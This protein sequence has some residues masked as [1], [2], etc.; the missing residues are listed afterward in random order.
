MDIVRLGRTYKNLKRLR[1]ILNVFAKYGF[2]YIVHRI[3][4][5]R[6]IS[7]RKRV[8]KP[9]EIRHTDI[10]DSA[11]KIRL[12]CEELGP[13]FVKFGQLMSL[14]A[15]ILPQH[16]IDELSNLQDSVKP[17]SYAEAK[18]I[19]KEEIGEP[20]ENVFSRLDELPCASA[21]M[22]QVHYAV[23]KKNKKKVIVKVQRPGIKNEINRDLDILFYLARLVEKHL[24]E[25]RVYNPVGMLEEFSSAINRELDF[26]YEM[27]HADKIKSIFKEKK[28]IRIP[29]VY[30]EYSGERVMVMEYLDG[31]KIRTVAAFSKEKKHELAKKLI[32]AYYIMVFEQGYFHADPHPGN[33][34][35][36]KDNALGLIDFGST[37]KLSRENIKKFAFMVLS[38]MEK[39]LNINIEEYRMLGIVS[40]EDENSGFEKEAITMMERYSRYPLNK[41]NIG[42]VVYELSALGRK[43]NLR[44]NKDFILLGKVLYTVESVIRGLDPA[45]N[46]VKA[47]EPHALK[48]IR[49]SME[50]KSL[51]IDAKNNALSMYGFVRNLPRD[52]SEIFKKIKKGELEIEFVHVGLEPLIHEID[53]ATNRLAFS[54]IIG[55]LLVGSSIVTYA[56]IGPRLL[57]IPLYGFIG[58]F[59][60]G[61][62]GVAIA[63][64]I[65]RSG[66]L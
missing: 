46:F 59:I 42:N 14:R 41:I 18:I 37:G 27:A 53:R 4:L 55:G 47:A 19:I 65:L 23:L 38:F 63:L 6:H 34:L 13:T 49:K 21:S 61:V 2:E 29:S 3:N 15:D 17:F 62:L 44:L 43:Y 35:V 57:D 45:F 52:I 54:F 11:H 36:L 60:A 40:E 9:K 22:S 12:M 20:L 58:Y 8:L 33:I 28:T 25:Y 24:P 50:P 48:F 56:G 64:S 5:S 39:D 66:K 26:T 32:D 7:L 31:I 10:F 51:L 1:E 30:F 16:F